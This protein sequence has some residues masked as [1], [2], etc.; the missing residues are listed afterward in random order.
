MP[1]ERHLVLFAKTPALGRAKRR[2]AAEVGA[3][4]ALRFY[5]ATLHRLILR[6]GRDRRWTTHLALAPGPATARGLPAAGGLHIFAQS[7]G[8]IGERMGHAIADCPPGPTILI[9]ADIPAVTPSHI[10]RAFDAL[11]GNDVVFGP[12]A[13][14]GFWLVGASGAGRRKLVFAEN[15][16]WSSSHA[17]ADTIAGLPD[18]ARVATADT[19]DDIDTAAALAR[20]RAEGG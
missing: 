6:L 11:R 13:D 9:G 4:E 19:M 17:L 5:R 10:A 1:L 16:R 3:V 14:G 12:A 8:D 20:W 15:V 18:G 7:G 2:L